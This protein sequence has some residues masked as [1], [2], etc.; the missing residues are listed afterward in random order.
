[1]S[2]PSE[3][4][5]LPA[6]VLW[7]MD[8]T[9]VD[10]E[11][12]W[13]AVQRRLVEEHGGRWSEELAASLVGRPL[14]EGAR[15][16][17][18]AGLDLPVEEVIA[19]T[20]GEVA[21]GVADAPPWRPG[22]HEL[23]TAQAEAGVPGALVTM[24]HAP[25]ARVLAEQA[26]AGALR[27]VVT[28]DEVTAGKPDPEAYRLALTRLGQHVPGLAVEDCVAVEDSPVGVAAA[29]AAGLPTVGVPSVLPLDDG[30]ATVRWDTLAGR[31]LDDLAAVRPGGRR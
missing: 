14:D 3:H 11:P 16:L 31:T 5:A 17:Q 4:P 26:P 21:R 13:N 29:M 28:G 25:L 23:L 24:S 1:M 7:D 30:A 6:A 8:G 20:M 10:T 15:R 22:A 2:A 27:V 9:L 19:L 18:E 12:L